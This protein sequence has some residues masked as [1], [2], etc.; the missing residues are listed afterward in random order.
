MRDRV[1]AS[2]DQSIIEASSLFEA[3]LTAVYPAIAVMV[4]PSRVLSDGA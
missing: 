2:F 4:T 1:H 3:L